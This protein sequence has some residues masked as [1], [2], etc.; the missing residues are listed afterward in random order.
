MSG[1]DDEA[2]LVAFIDGRLDNS[3][4][5]AFEA[6]LAREVGLRER[7]NQLQVGDRPFALAFQA[8]LE[9]APVERLSASLGA[10]GDGQGVNKALGPP[11]SLRVSRIAA[12]AA[13]ILFCLGIIGGRYGPAWLFPPS[14]IA[15]PESDRE[16]WRQAVAEYMGLYTSDT[17]AAG[18]SAQQ[19][20][21]ATLGAKLGVALTPERI[22]LASL[23]FRSA[24]IF[25]FEGAPLGQLAY[26]DP[27]TGPVLFCI[28]HN[29]E[30]DAPM[31]PGKRGGFSVTSWAR[32]GHGYMLI[33]RLPANQMI[34]LADSLERRF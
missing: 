15:A 1:D 3:A 13:I 34:A 12:A 21:L 16:D 7:L 4:V 2:E 17:F 20:E 25:D 23:Q 18:A 26:I 32:A 30:P 5:D 14:E 10:L 8:L 24:Q 6:R 33:G 27:A 31:K 9:E 19:D 11:S 28:I 22:A 29:A